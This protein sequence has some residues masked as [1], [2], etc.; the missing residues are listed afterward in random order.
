MVR[1]NIVKIAKR[2]IIQYRKVRGMSQTEL[3]RKMKISQRLVAYYESKASNISLEKLQDFADALDVSVGALLD[4]R[5][6]VPEVGPR[7]DIRILK[8][9]QQ[10]ESLPRRARDALLHNINTAIQVHSPKCRKK[11][12]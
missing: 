3:A 9:V 4:E 12:K 10:I 1:K 5:P 11:G 2:N 8:R 6:A 7:V